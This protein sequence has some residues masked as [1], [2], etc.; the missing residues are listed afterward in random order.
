MAYNVDK[1]IAKVAWKCPVGQFKQCSRKPLEGKNLCGIHIA[2]NPHGTVVDPVEAKEQP[3]LGSEAGEQPGEGGHAEEQPSLGSEAGEQPGEGGH[4]EEQP[5]LGSEAGEQ[6]GEGG[7]ALVEDESG[8]GE[9]EHEIADLKQAEPEEQA[10]LVEGDGGVP[11]RP[12][13]DALAKLDT[14]MPLSFN[15]DNLGDY[16]KLAKADVPKANHDQLIHF[17]A[18]CRQMPKDSC[19][20]NHVASLIVAV[21]EAAILGNS[22]ELCRLG[23]RIGGRSIRVPQSRNVL[24]ML[25]DVLR[26]LRFGSCHLSCCHISWPLGLSPAF[27]ADPCEH[28]LRPDF[29]SRGVGQGR[30]WGSRMQ[31]VCK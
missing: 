22:N 4:A 20:I 28:E 31:R 25:V 14:D 1:C 27:F 3:S 9:H 18:F 24:A 10:D 5:S 8:I 23:R 26:I 17:S 11:K 6:P 12:R 7:D 15:F 19:W 29:A 13:V 2:N 16:L 21:S 30:P